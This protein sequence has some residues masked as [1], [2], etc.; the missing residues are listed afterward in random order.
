MNQ[1]P[2]NVSLLSLL[3]MSGD[4]MQICRQSGNIA[5]SGAYATLFMAFMQKR[6]IY[7]IQTVL[8]ATWAHELLITCIWHKEI[9]TSLA[10]CAT[11]DISWLSAAFATSHLIVEII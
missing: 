11:C 9:T 4:L 7:L 6:V 2:A 5:S 10:T 8:G 3:T 1:C